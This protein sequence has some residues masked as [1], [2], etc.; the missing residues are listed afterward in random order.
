MKWA[1]DMAMAVLE[2]LGMALE[3]VEE[4]PVQILESLEGEREPRERS[5]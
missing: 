2:A 3:G 1:M 5:G 4:A